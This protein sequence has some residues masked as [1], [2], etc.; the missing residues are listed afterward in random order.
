MSTESEPPDPSEEGVLCPKCLLANPPSAAFCSD[1]GAPIGMVTTVDPMQQIY[2]EGFAYR[3]A[4][5][6]PPRLIVVIGMWMIFGPM[7]LLP[8]VPLFTRIASVDSEEIVY[9]FLA[10]FSIVILYRTTKN[11][12]VKSR[13]AQV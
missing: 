13:R 3:S 8:L 7:A 4:V 11:Y 2:S 5:D 1:C 12:V 9:L 6:G 10:L